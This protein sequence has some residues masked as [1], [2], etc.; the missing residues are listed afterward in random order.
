MVVVPT[1]GVR[2]KRA[3]GRGHVS[4]SMVFSCPRVSTDLVIEQHC[5][6]LWQ[7]NVV[8]ET[9]GVSR[10]V[11]RVSRNAPPFPQSPADVFLAL[12]TVDRPTVKLR[13]LS[14][15]QHLTHAVIHTRNHATCT[16]ARA[17]RKCCGSPQT[18]ARHVAITTQ[19]VDATHTSFAVEGTR[20]PCP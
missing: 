17:R 1:T 3:P 7:A 10:S 5:L 18:R 13:P 19:H 11:P 16:S 2:V 8:D 14:L 9:Q 6:A 15:H 12:C 4:G 20:E